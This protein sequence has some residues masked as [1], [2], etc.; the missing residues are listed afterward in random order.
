MFSDLQF[1]RAPISG[2]P[3]PSAHDRSPMSAMGKACKQEYEEPL[4]VPALGALNWSDFRRRFCFIFTMRLILTSLR[5][6]LRRVNQFEG[7]TQDL[8]NLGGILRE[9]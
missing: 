7:E 1:L 3:V 2:S 6:S 5:T 8:R 9:I 4:E